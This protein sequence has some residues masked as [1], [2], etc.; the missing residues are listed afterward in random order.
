MNKKYF[1]LVFLVVIIVVAIYW[2]KSRSNNLSDLGKY[3]NLNNY[4][5]LKYKSSVI[6][7]D[8]MEEWLLFANQGF[9]DPLLKNRNLLGEDLNTSNI[10]SIANSLSGKIVQFEAGA[11]RGAHYI[12]GKDKNFNFRYAFSDDRKHLYIQSW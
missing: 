12:I 1:I 2:K 3:L 9:A 6:S 10:T 11:E 7:K 4:S 8:R 5:V